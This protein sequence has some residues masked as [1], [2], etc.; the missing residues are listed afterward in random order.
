MGCVCITGWLKHLIYIVMFNEYYKK[1][2]SLFFQQLHP[3]KTLAA[4]MAGPQGLFLTLPPY[5][6]ELQWI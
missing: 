6:T 5:H 4:T 1:V 3:L 2:E